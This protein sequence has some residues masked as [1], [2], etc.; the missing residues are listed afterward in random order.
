MSSANIAEQTDFVKNQIDNLYYPGAFDDMAANEPERLT[1]EITQLLKDVTDPKG[2]RF[3]KVDTEEPQQPETLSIKDKRDILKAMSR[4]VKP[5][6]GEE[7]QYDSINEAIVEVFYKPEGHN[8]L[9][10]FNQWK[11]KGFAV[12]KGEKALFVW[13]SPVDRNKD[14]KGNKID[15]EKDEEEFYPLCFLFSN[16]QVA[17]SK[18]KENATA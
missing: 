2:F 6:V 17:Q 1:A 11:E 5:L 3:T 4:A 10:T 8:E 14:S 15:P 16:K 9:Y 13:G 18:V 12:R 7:G